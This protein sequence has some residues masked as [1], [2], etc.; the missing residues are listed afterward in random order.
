MFGTG[1]VV[2]VAPL[3]ATVLAAVEDRYAGI[4]SAINN[5][6]ARVANLLA[7]PSA[8]A[9]KP[10]DRIEMLTNYDKTQTALVTWT[11]LDGGTAD[12]FHFGQPECRG[13]HLG[14]DRPGGTHALRRGAG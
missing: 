3:T 5:A 7:M 8:I 11:A 13:L 9:A 2:V 1:L 4:G 6:V 14:R 10:G 12:A